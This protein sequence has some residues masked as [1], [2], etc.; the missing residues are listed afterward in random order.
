MTTRF[1]LLLG[2]AAV[3]P[4][5]ALAPVPPGWAAAG[6]HIVVIVRHAETEG[7]GS[8]P[9]L[10]EAGRQRAEALARIAAAYEVEAA[11]ATPYRRTQETAAPAA[12]W[13]GLRTA[14]VP[15]DAGIPA[16]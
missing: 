10:S 4:L 12:G 5:V 13:L 3:A 15:I 16:H 1:V 11:F 7:G 2:L 14:A 6:D 9:Q 8:D